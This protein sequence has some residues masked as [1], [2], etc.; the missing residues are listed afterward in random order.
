MVELVEEEGFVMEKNISIWDN[1]DISQTLNA[2]FKLEYMAPKKNG[3][4]PIVEINYDGIKAEINFWKHVVVC[5]MLGP[6]PIFEV[7]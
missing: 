1:F 7:L 2:G 5:Y 4:P 6:Y 3:E